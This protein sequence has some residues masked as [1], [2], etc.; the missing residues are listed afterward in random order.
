MALA[1]NLQCDHIHLEDAYVA[2]GNDCP[3]SKVPACIWISV[4]RVR[5]LLCMNMVSD[6]LPDVDV[7]NQY[8]AISALWTTPISWH[9]AC[10]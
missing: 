9:A 8:I 10:E 2:G 1:L 5:H 4:T 7:D 3:R 6:D